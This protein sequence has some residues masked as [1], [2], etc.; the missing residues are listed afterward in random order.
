MFIKSTQIKARYLL[1]H[2][3][4][5]EV[6]LKNIVVIDGHVALTVHTLFAHSGLSFLAFSYIFRVRFLL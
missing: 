5:G 3:L 4:Q 1:E 2:I 6:R